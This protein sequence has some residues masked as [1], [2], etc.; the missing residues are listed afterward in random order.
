[1]QTVSIEKERLRATLVANMEGHI[2]DYDEAM[3]GYREAFDKQLMQKRRALKKGELPT[4]H[5]N[6]LPMPSEHTSEYKQV[7]EMLDYSVDETIEL[8]H[9]DF[10]NYVLDNWD[11]K[12]RFSSTNSSYKK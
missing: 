11:W 3:L 4:T 8:S 1:M 6:G 2:A 5:F 7:L 9:D 12:G 10:G